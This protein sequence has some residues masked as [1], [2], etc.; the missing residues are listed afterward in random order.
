MSALQASA[1]QAALER[2]SDASVV[3]VSDRRAVAPKFV[4]SKPPSRQVFVI[5]DNELLVKMYRAIFGA[6]GVGVVHAS[7]ERDARHLFEHSKP[8]LF[9]VD[10][11]KGTGLDALREIRSRDGFADVPVI[12]TVSDASEQ[13][14]A[15]LQAAGIASVVTKPLQLTAFKALA[16]RHLARRAPDVVA[17]HEAA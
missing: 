10:D 4:A 9:I 13:L 16:S 1:A 12:A 2:P 15:D 3:R 8:A 14:A 7:T 6:M 17:C 11:D 5:E